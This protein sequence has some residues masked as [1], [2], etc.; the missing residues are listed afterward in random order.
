MKIT[1]LSFPD[2]F[3]Y[4]GY[5]MTMYVSVL[6]ATPPSH[7]GPAT[8]PYNLKR[9][10][11]N[12]RISELAPSSNPHTFFLVSLILTQTL[13]H[14]YPSH[15]SSHT[16]ILSS[17]QAAERCVTTSYF[18]DFV[19]VPIIAL[20]FLMGGMSM[21][22]LIFSCVGIRRDALCAWFAGW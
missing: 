22:Y 3:Y 17:M 19:I 1:K 2:D 5:H 16:Q 14:S 7:S 11:L 10:R 6:N 21:I 12:T 4:L 9:S 13:S 18:L 20:V 8:L 15:C